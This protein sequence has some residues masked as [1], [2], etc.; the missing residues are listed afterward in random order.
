[1]YAFHKHPLWFRDSWRCLMG[2]DDSSITAIGGQ[3]SI[4]L[5]P[6]KCVQ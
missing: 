2:R 4:S 6:G 3:F 1:M 5:D